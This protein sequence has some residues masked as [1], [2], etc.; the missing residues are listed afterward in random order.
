MRHRLPSR[1]LAGL[2]VLAFAGVSCTSAPPTPSARP[3]DPPKPAASA[4]TAPAAAPTPAA[5]AKPTT[6]P[7]AASARPTDP[8]KP[9]APATTAPA[10]KP[11]MAATQK[12][13][14]ALDLEPS[15]IDPHVNQSDMAHRVI[16]NVFDP[17]VFQTADGTVH[18]GLALSWDISAD[19]RTYTFKLRQGVTFHDGTPFNA[20]AVKFSF[21]R[22]RNPDTKSQL[23]LPM[24]GPIDSYEAVD[25]TTFRVQFKAAYPAFLDALSC[26]WLAP[27]SPAAVQKFGADFGR[28]LVGT[29]PFRFKE[30]VAKDRIVL[31]KNPDYNWAPT[32]FKHQG[33]AYLDEVT[34]RFV[35]NWSA[36]SAVLETGELDVSV[37]APATDVNRLKANSR[38]KV[39][40]TPQP[41]TSQMLLMNYGRAPT[42]ELAVRQAI[43]YALDRKS[44]V[45]VLDAGLLM[46]AFGP[47]TRATTAY[48]KSVE[49]QYAFNQGRARQILDEA[50]WRPDPAAGG[51]REKNG[52]PLTLQWVTLSCCQLSN[53]GELIQAMLREV[54]IDVAVEL[55][56]TGPAYFAAVAENKHHLTIGGWF[57]SDPG[58][59]SSVFHSKNVAANNRGKVTLPELDAMLDRAEAEADAGRRAALYGQV[60]KLVMD[61][62]LAAPIRDFSD[63]LVTRA[64][65][66]GLTFDRRGAY[67]WLYD[68]YLKP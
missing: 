36:R 65:L 11:A 25:D 64:T 40:I 49:G 55:S 60:Q 52:Q 21:D 57:V 35:E 47:L 15:G 30:W 20:Q 24:L 26:A 48:D 50:G 34:F 67:F 45:D 37:N 23:A 42:S 16:M 56:A 61:Q 46:P 66:D 38:L 53:M 3:T 8:P 19:G 63:I 44:V 13:A 58:F 59:L 51:I 62:A 2:V 5:A 43:N 10:A 28:N 29:G 12:I 9:A 22:I 14:Y 7:A 33:P 27:V 68:A 31:E 18:P 41:G 4:T 32:F 17:L 1:F 39:V 6:V 54:G